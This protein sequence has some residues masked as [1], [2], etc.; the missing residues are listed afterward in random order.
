MAVN[1]LLVHLPLEPKDLTTKSAQSSLLI[2][3]LANLSSVKIAFP[4]PGSLFKPPGRIIVQSKFVYV[5]KSLSA[6]FLAVNADSKALYTVSGIAWIVSPQPT[7]EYYI[8]SL[9]RIRV[10]RH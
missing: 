7:L 9:I 1:S 10:P 2:T 6:L 8:I 3:P 5:F 4:V